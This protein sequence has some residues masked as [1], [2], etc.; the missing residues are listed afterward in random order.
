MVMKNSKNDV[1][2]ESIRARTLSKEDSTKKSDK[3]DGENS[4]FSD[5]KTGHCTHETGNLQKEIGPGETFRFGFSVTSFPRL[6][7]SRPSAS[8]VLRIQFWVLESSRTQDT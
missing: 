5:V 1:E 3:S 6:L 2:F 8:C 7:N 4:G